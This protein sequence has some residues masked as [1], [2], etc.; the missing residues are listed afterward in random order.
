MS[1]AEVDGPQPSMI[2]SMETLMGMM[3]Q[4]TKKF[5][6]QEKKFGDQMVQ[7]LYLMLKLIFKL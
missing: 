5:D 6:D 3:G 2:K 1:K 4:L 7:L